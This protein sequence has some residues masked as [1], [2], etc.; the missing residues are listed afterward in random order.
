MSTKC[1]IDHGKTWHLYEDAIDETVWIETRAEPFAACCG[2]VRVQ[3]PAALID[4]IRKAKPGHF[5]HL[6]TPNATGEGSEV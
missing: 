6:R 4:A 3:M 5:P 2:K 1:T